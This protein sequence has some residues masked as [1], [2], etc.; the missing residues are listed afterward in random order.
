[1]K[2]TGTIGSGFS[3]SLG[4]IVASHNSFATYFRT[5]AIPVNTQTAQQQAVRSVFATL[6]SRWTDTLTQVQRD[7]WATYALNTPGN[8]SALNWYIA[9]N[10]VRRQTAPVG[11][12]PLAYVDNAPTN[13]SLANL[14]PPSIAATSGSPGEASVVF[15]N[16]DQWANEV[17]GA[18]LIQ[19]ARQYSPSINFF[20]GPFQLAHML[21]GAV[22]PP[23]SPL[24]VDSMF[25]AAAGNKMTARFIACLADGRISAPTLATDIIV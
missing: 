9:C 20:V 10:S 21:L 11:G 22:I 2:F 23:T 14:T 17:G 13:F 16:T 25:A 5:R 3:G 15:A 7:G 4:G 6:A 19:I 8:K 24:A 18:L 12:G 1:M